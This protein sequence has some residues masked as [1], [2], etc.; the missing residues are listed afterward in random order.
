MN[1]RNDNESGKENLDQELDFVETEQDAEQEEK[2]ESR[3][4]RAPSSS[5]AN[6]RRAR[7]RSTEKVA[8]SSA[9]ES[10]DDENVSDNEHDRR[11][12]NG[13]YQ[14]KRNYET[15]QQPKKGSIFSKALI[16]IV[17][18]AIIGAGAFAYKEF[19][20]KD[21]EILMAKIVA[22]NPNYATI[23]IPTTKC[24]DETTSKQVA[25]PNRNF[26][27]GLF[28]SKNHPKYVTKTST[29]QVCEQVNLESQV[30]TNYTVQYQVKNNLESMIV[31]NPP[32]INAL[33]PVSQLQLYVESA[34]N[35]PETANSS[36]VQ[37]GVKPL[38]S[39]T[40]SQ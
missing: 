39:G 11:Y 2:P 10:L 20:G 26:I 15:H 30:L 21:D 40:N 9:D 29:K 38:S 28:D 1:K 34:N 32:Q 35:T 36:S 25:N 4:R 14:Q 5:S 7:P 18:L 31:Q 22:V 19:M 8:S 12:Q 27:N 3:R 16:T 6:V 37:V 23:Q 17:V 24:H 13:D 33:I